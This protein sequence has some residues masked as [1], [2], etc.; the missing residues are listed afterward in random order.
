[1][2]IPTWLLIAAGIID[3]GILVLLIYVVVKCCG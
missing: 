2:R 1:M 3:V